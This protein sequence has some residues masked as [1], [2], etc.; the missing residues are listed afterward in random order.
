LPRT[1]S[2]LW[3]CKY[4]KKIFFSQQFSENSRIS[5]YIRVKT[6]RKQTGL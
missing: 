6:N 3:D 4:L 1:L 5:C 2:S